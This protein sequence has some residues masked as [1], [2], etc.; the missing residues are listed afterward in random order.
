TGR[1]SVR[2]LTMDA[3]NR[4]FLILAIAGSVLPLAWM[5]ARSQQIT[6][7]DILYALIPW[8][9]YGVYLVTRV[10]VRTEDHVRRCLWISMGA[11]SIVALIAILQ[12]VQLFGVPHLLARYYT[13]YGVTSALT[14]F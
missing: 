5:L 6:Q 9:Y 14:N 4:S 3:T 11:A 10:S 13:A 7:D 2:S 12:S 8:K 1:P